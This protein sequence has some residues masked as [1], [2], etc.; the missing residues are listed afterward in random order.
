[1]KTV[2]LAGPDVFA[3][4]PAALGSA[5]KAICSRH[6]LRGLFP[7]DVTSLDPDW[8]KREKSLAVYDGLMRAMAGDCDGALVNMTPFGGIGMD[9]GTAFEA[10]VFAVLGKPVFAYANTAAALVERAAAHWRGALRRDADGAWRGGDGMEID[11]LG[12]FENLMI[13][14]CVI[15]STGVFVA[16]TVPEAERFTALGPFERCV[17]MAADWFRAHAL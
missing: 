15:R 13:D 16:E 6:G 2:Y 9:I 12:E 14:A 4:D 7:M 3:P 11:G 8:S 10:G 17:G 5:K 1:M